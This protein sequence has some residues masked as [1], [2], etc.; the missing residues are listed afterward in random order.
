M[1]T[2]G[3]RVP[4]VARGEV[5][6]VDA[7]AGFVARIVG[8]DVPIV[9]VN[10]RAG[11]AL[12]VCA[13]VIQGA[14]I[15]VVASTVNR[16]I[17][18]TFS[19]QAAIQGAR[20]GVVA[21]RGSGVVA[22]PFLAEVPGGANVAIVARG[23]V[24]LVVA[25]QRLIAQVVG[26]HI[27]V[28]AVQG[29]AANAL[30]FC[31]YVRFGA[32]ATI[33]ALKDV[34]FI[35]A[36]F[37]RVA[38]LVGASV[39]VIAV[40]RCAA[41]ADA[42]GALA[43]HRALVFVNAG[44]AVVI[45]NQGANPRARVAGRG[46]A[47]CVYA[48]GCGTFDERVRIHHALERHL[49]VIAKQSAVAQVPVF[50]LRAIVVGL[51]IAGYGGACALAVVALISEGA[52]VTVVAGPLLGRKLAPAG[53][54]TE[55]F[56][57]RVRVVAFYHQGHAGPFFAMVGHGAGVAVVA[58]ARFHGRVHAP[59]GAGAAIVCAAVAVFAQVDVI[60]V[61]QVRFVGFVVAVVILPVALLRAR[62][63]GVAFAK[64]VIGTHPHARATS[65]LIL[66]FARRP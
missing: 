28:V 17:L 33:V 37:Q 34:V 9:T 19:G 15:A 2:G 3:A 18:T 54:G 8:A 53:R 63:F 10:R 12:T 47:G 1:V 7:K 16:F 48:V 39:A 46:Q 41:S 35:N 43:V 56:G 22:L 42:A 66:G 24:G 20:I 13:G 55:V 45:R 62:N 25:S 40:D 36:P 59:F 61:H 32:G 29:R 21:V 60:A 14:R 38:Q 23:V 6:G 44:K 58:T 27:A 51:A 30:A 52:R 4:V 50:Q 64:A 65:K 49:L 11:R 31:T 57:A 5:G 26:A